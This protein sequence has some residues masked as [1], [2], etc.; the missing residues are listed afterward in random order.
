[1]IT[2]FLR[3]T[4]SILKKSGE[5][6]VVSWSNVSIE[7]E[8][9]KELEVE[10]LA[11]KESFEGVFSTSSIVIK[12]NASQYAFQ[13]AKEVAG[14]DTTVLLQGETGVGKGIYAKFRKLVEC[15]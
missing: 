8:H 6:L 3:E 5:E 7:V 9:E 12:S 1:M 11:L 4:D 14:V 10:N 15:R 2:L 13:K